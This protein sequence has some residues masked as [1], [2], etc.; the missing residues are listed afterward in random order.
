MNTPPRYDDDLRDDPEVFKAPCPACGDPK[1]AMMVN[2]GKALG[3]LA[4]C[5]ACHYTWTVQ[6]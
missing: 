2:R 5:R 1:K 4:R 6:P 3:F